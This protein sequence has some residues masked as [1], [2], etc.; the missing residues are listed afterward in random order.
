VL[1]PT[2]YDILQADVETLKP[3]YKLGWVVARA[4]YVR[5]AQ[6]AARLQPHLVYPIQRCSPLFGYVTKEAWVDY[7]PINWYSD[8]IQCVDMI[9]K[10]Y[11]HH[12]S[13]S[14][15]H[16]A[17]SQTIGMDHAANHS[18]AEPWIRDNRPELHKVW[19]K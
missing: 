11:T 18:A 7:P 19:F 15:I 4:D 6:I 16:H 8:D 17:G 13:R 1:T 2:S 14:Y 5:P 9:T 10:G 3:H 12:I